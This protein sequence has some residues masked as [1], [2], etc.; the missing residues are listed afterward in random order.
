MTCNSARAPSAA[1]VSAPPRSGS[2]S[3]TARP[4]RSYKPVCLNRAG[5]KFLGSSVI[6]L[7]RHTEPVGRAPLAKTYDG[8]DKPPAIRHTAEPNGQPQGPH[9]PAARSVSH[10]LLQRLV[11][12][13]RKVRERGGDIPVCI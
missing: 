10:R 6:S 12:R 13:N 2:S 8:R 7:E 1:C 4:A 3:S 9:R 11:A 5:E